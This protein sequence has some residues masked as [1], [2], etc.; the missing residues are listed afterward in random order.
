MRSAWALGLLGKGMVQV[1]VAGVAE[2]SL[3][4]YQDP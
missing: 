1:S 4:L 2:N 3:D